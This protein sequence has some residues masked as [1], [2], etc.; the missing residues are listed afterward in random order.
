VNEKSNLLRLA[1]VMDNLRSPGGCPWD[2]EQTHESLLTYLLEETYEFIDAVERADRDDMIEELG[3]VL[4]QVFFHA[5]IG[6]ERNVDEFSIEDVA[7][8]ICE[9][10]IRRHPHVFKEAENLTSAEV[11]GNWERIKALE[12]SRN[13][14]DEGVPL[15]QP[16]LALTSKLLHRAQAHGHTP[17]FT[18]RFSDLKEVS[19]ETIGELLLSVVSL[20]NENGVDPEF[21]LRARARNLVREIQ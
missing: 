3:D 1:E 12:K 11:E 4:L 7:G 13:S 9:K 14:A 19:E 8:A 17:A 20:A 10:L 15:G 21:A 5:R 16:A 18:R 6:Q 2:A